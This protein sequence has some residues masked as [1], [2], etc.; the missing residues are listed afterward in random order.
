MCSS[1]VAL[2]SQPR[3][4]YS[5]IFPLNLA[6]EILRMGT[7]EE[8]GK[9]V[10]IRS[11]KKRIAKRRTNTYTLY[12]G[13]H[14]HTHP[15]P[16]VYLPGTTKTLPRQRVPAFTNEVVAMPIELATLSHSGAQWGGGEDMEV[17]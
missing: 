9:A 12:I 3:V 8:F 14:T 1:C 4:S 5:V 6:A 10:N 7:K 15:H 13:T 17:C 11:Y 16:L 2:Q